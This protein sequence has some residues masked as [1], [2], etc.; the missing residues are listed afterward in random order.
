MPSKEIKLSLD[1]LK[2]LLSEKKERKKKKRK[3][4]KAKRK[5]RGI[6]FGEVKHDPNMRNYVTSTRVPSSAFPNTGA[7]ILTREID[8]FRGLVNEK[9]NKLIADDKPAKDGSTRPSEE[10]GVRILA[11]KLADDVEAGTRF[12]RSN[13]DGSVTVSFPI[14]NKPG[15]R[16]KKQTTSTDKSNK[17]V[18]VVDGDGIGDFGTKKT[19]K[20]AKIKKSSKP[21]LGS[22][23]LKD[24]LPTGQPKEEVYMPTGD[25]IDTIESQWIEHIEDPVDEDVLDIQTEPLEEPLE[26]APEE[27][28]EEALEEPPE[29]PNRT[30][31]KE[32]KQKM[33]KGKQD[34]Q[35]IAELNKQLIM[36]SSNVPAPEEKPKKKKSHTKIPKSVSR[37]R[38]KSGSDYENE[39]V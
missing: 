18:E 36:A 27:P 28:L 8:T 29:K 1:E 4:Q 33:K 30:L 39:F 12:M 38:D 21:L 9:V 16:E 17:V 10:T 24:Y 20:T 22:T 32:H 7:N 35:K 11:N 37:N 26:A 19:A 6:A 15:E 23:P 5:A 13:K 25:N 31:T 3:R 14:S 2:K 34:Q